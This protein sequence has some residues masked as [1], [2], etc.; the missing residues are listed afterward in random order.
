MPTARLGIALSQ[1]GG[2]VEA[3]CPTRHVIRK[4]TVLGKAYA[5]KAL[6]PLECFRDAI[7]GARPDLIVSAD[8][9]STKHLIDLHAQEKRNG[10]ADSGICRL[11]ERSLGPPESFP[12][13]TSR[14]PF[15]EFAQQE[16]IRIPKT[17]VIR[18]GRDLDVWAQESGFPVVLKADGSSSGEGTKVAWTLQEAERTLRCLQEPVELIRVVKRVIVNRDLRSVRPKLQHRRAVVNAQKYI[19]GRDATTLVACWKGT[20]LG[21]LHFEVVEKQYKLGPASVM[22]ILNNPEIEGFVARIVSRLKLSGLHGFDFLLEE[23]TL[24][25]YMIEFNPRAT[26]VGHLTL[27]KGADLPGALYAAVTTTPPR[28]APKMT[29]NPIIALFPQESIRDPDSSFLKTGYHDVPAGEPELIRESLRQGRK[30]AAQHLLGAYSRL[31]STD[32]HVVH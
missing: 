30:G 15:M 31:F 13:M 32:R 27:G 9:L 10:S 6:S 26:Q 29:D 2:R 4:A 25:P 1:T 22:R 18:N 3:I 17:G 20:I 12:F 8:D 24:L 5:Y 28:E 23:G 21:A 11:I 14:T 7:N 16:G 19:V